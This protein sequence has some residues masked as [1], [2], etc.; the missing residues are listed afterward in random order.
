MKGATVT[1]KSMPCARPHAA[2][3]PSVFVC[4][5]TLASVW[6]PT[7]STAPA[8]RSFCSGLP[9]WFSVLRST[10]SAAPSERR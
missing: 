10:I 1:G 7:E 6:L 5:Q 3:T 2:T 9:A 8:Q 4:A